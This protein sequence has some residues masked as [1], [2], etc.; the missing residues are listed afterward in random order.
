MDAQCK[1]VLSVLSYN[2]ILI[3]DTEQKKTGYE[4]LVY[5]VHIETGAYTS[6]RVINNV[7]KLVRSV[8]DVPKG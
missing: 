2:L 7:T 1:A 3:P 8:L 4:S 6:F 5:V